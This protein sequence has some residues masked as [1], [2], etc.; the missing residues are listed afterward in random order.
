MA[1]IVHYLFHNISSLLAVKNE[2]WSPHELNRM[3]EPIQP[4][5]QFF[6]CLEAKKQG[7]SGVGGKKSSLR[8]KIVEKSILGDLPASAT[9]FLD[10]ANHLIKLSHCFS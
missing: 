2:P 6:L 10:I 4:M 1:A 3:E 9:R 5:P 7:I 8:A